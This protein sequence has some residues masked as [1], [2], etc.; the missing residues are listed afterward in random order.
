MRALPVREVIQ[1]GVN[2][3]WVV[4][5]DAGR[6]VTRAVETLELA[7]CIS[8]GVQAKRQISVPRHS[9][10]ASKRRLWRRCV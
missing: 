2:G 9:G 10:P 8:E 1:D 6:L 5:F 7:P 3:R 4:I